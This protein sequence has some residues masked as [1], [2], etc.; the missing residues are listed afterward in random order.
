VRSSAASPHVGSVQ[1]CSWEPRSE[2]A[3]SAVSSRVGSLQPV[4]I[5]GSV[6][7]RDC[8]IAT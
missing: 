8:S 3:C 4:G 1:H 5:V 6:Q 7:H 2:T